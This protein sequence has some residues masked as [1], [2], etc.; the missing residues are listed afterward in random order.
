MKSITYK[1]SDSEASS[2]LSGSCSSPFTS[3]GVSLVLPLRALPTYPRIELTPAVSLPANQPPAFVAAPA[4]ALATETAAVAAVDVVDDI[5]ELA[6]RTCEVHVTLIHIL[7]T[8][9][10]IKHRTQVY[11]ARHRRA[12]VFVVDESSL[13]VYIRSILIYKKEYR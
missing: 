2:A 9:Q 5:I 10:Y 13:R 11:R 4:V 8:V 3:T 7:L 1:C 6:R 12:R